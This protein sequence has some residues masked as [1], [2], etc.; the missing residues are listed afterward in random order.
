MPHSTSLADQLS[1]LHSLISAAP[2]PREIP[3]PH[4]EPRPAQLAPP[5]PAQ[6]P[7]QAPIPRVL[8]SLPDAAT[9]REGIKLSPGAI[10]LHDHLHAVALDV[11]RHR[12]HTT[13]PDAITYHLPAV[14]VAALARYSERHTYRLADELRRAGLIDERGHVAQ[15][16]KLRRYSG[17]IWSVA[18]RPGA[19]TRLRWF[20]FQHDWRPDFSQDYH[21]E[22]G[23]FREVQEAMAEPFTCDREAR[24]YMLA[25]TWATASR[26]APNPAVGGS[27]TRP[28]HVLAQVAY[29]L[30]ALVQLH[31]GTVTGRSPASL[32]ILPMPWESRAA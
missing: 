8:P 30:P 17:T 9:V 19:P 4:P 23:A 21:G 13:A 5:R 24:V 26:T 12:A 29:A 18:L 15:V 3:A 1:R 7:E 11:A 14:I 2:Q 20:D 27:A 16:G 25:R 32:P 31:P 6:R 28:G 22:T 10:R